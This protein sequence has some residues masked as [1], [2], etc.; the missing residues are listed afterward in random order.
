MPEIL[1]QPRPR[2]RSKSYSYKTNVVWTGQRAGIMH[3]LRKPSVRVASP[4]EFRGEEGVWTPEDLFVSA[5][6]ICL[7][8]TFVALAER[9]ALAIDSFDSD[10]EGLLELR[11]G[12]FTFTKVTLRPRIVVSDASTVEAAGQLLHAAHESC[13][14][15][16]S[17]RADV[18]VDPTIGTLGFA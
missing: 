13:L 3:S 5:I 4:P 2:V 9:A 10:A 16:N 15:G 17:I 18:I 14:I 6:N 12:G 7:M 1:E 8:T 11:D